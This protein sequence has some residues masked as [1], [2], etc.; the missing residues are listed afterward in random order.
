MEELVVWLDA[1]VGFVAVVDAVLVAAYVIEELDS[2]EWEESAS[3]KSV[4][5]FAED[6]HDHTLILLSPGGMK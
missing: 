5:E 3:A 1:S 4:P 6:L 2:V